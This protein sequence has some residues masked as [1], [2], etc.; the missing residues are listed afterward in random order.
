MRLYAAGTSLLVSF[1]ASGSCAPTPRLIPYPHPL[2]IVDRA[3]RSSLVLVGV[4]QSETTV[5]GG[6]YAEGPDSMPLEL[7][8]VGVHV[9]GIIKG[10]YEDRDLSFV[11]YHATGPWDGPAPNLLVP[12]ERA[13]F[14][15]ISDSGTLRATN[16]AYSSHTEI[17]TG[18]HETQPATESDR[19]REMI[20]RLLLLPG[21]G[22]DIGKY[23]ASLYVERAAA[24]EVVSEAQTADLLRLLLRNSNGQIRG[25]ACILLAQPPLANKDCLASLINDAEASPDDRKR[26]E[27]LRAKPSARQ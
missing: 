19:V 4:V 12:G 10:Q 25:R 16:D 8:R 23:V 14:Y 26:A 3:E 5:R 24:L 13:I 7:R 1:F 20:A 9:E 15:L 17:V 22:V 11:Y 18:R 2:G 21:D 27:E 6:R